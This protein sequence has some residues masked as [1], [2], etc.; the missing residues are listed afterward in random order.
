[1]SAVSLPRILFD[2]YLITYLSLLAW[3]ILDLGVL[4]DALRTRCRQCT[5]VQKE[6]ALDVITRLYYEFP[7][8][9]TALAERYDPNG[10]YTRNFEN[11]F[12][13]QNAVKPGPPRDEGNSFNV[14]DNVAIAQRPTNENP[15]KPQGSESTQ[16]SV[17]R[18]P[19]VET[20]SRLDINEVSTERTRIPSTWITKR[21]TIMTTERS[22]STRAPLRTSP[23]RKSTQGTPRTPQ[24]VVRAPAASNWP[25]SFTAKLF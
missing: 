22:T 6:K 9:Y 18:S 8:S 11:W 14:P 3:F 19:A 24:V 1:M 2:V 25:V 4:P 10:E 7:S 17:R 13:E 12:D 23:T 16:Q 15:S 20:G 21:T 5:T